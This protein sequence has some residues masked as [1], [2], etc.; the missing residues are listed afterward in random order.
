MGDWQVIIPE[1]G[2]NFVYNPVAM[3]LANYAAGGATPA[4]VTLDTTHSYLGHRSYHVV[5]ALTT[6]SILLT[7]YT[8]ANAIH[9]LTVRVHG[10]LPAGWVCG[11]DVG[12][13]HTM[14]LLATEGDWSVYGHQ[15]SAAESVGQTEVIFVQLDDGV[16]DYYIGHVQ[17]EQ[18]TYPTTPITGD[19]RGF[20]SDGYVWGGTPNDSNSWRKVYERSGG[21]VVDLLDTYNWKV[22]YGVGTGMP[23]IQH[24]TQG[25]ALLPGALYGGHKVLPR[26]LDLVSGTQANTP[27]TVTAARKNF[28]NAIKPDRSV[29]EQPVVFR[30]TGANVN[31]PIEF[32][33]IYDSGLENQITSGV[34]DKPTVRF[35]CYD[36]FAY[37]THTESKELIRYSTIADANYVVWK[38]NGEWANIDAGFDAS[39]LGFVQG[40]DGC[41]YIYGGFTL[42]VPDTDYVAKW[43]PYTEVL[44]ILAGTGA[45]AVV[46]DGICDANGNIYFCGNFTNLGGADGDYIAMWDGAAFQPLSTGLTAAGS[47]LEIG[48]D[49]TLFIGGSFTNFI[50]GSG[51]YITKWDGAA[52]S[53]MGTG[54]QAGVPQDFAIAPNGDLY[55]T[56][57]FTTAGGVANTVQIAKWNGAAWL[58]LGTGLAGG[59]GGY[60]IAS[61]KAGNIY[62]G[63]SFTTADGVSCL[64]IAKWNGKTFEPLGSGLNDICYDLHIDSDGLLYAMGSFTTA[65]G[66]T[67]PDTMAVWNGSTWG[68]LDI[69][70]PGAAICQALETY[71]NDM[72]IGYSDV[73]SA[74]ASYTNSIT[75]SNSGS[76]I[77][78]PIIRIQR[79]GGTSCNLRWIRNETTHQTIRCN[80]SL[81]LGETLTI[82]L[83]PGDRHVTSDYFGDVWRAVLRGSDLATFGLIGGTN[84]ITVFCSEVGAA[85][86]FISW[87]E[88]KITHWSADTAA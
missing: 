83:T 22:L 47:C 74:I 84:Q 10:T 79:V 20:T 9:Y 57:A 27:A 13:W 51:D 60:A 33:C 29:P 55:V 24:H 77:T 75:V 59:S 61:D 46:N 82:D 56:G 64:N 86:D 42:D 45:N 18:N 80:Y 21:K 66:V 35:I 14:T 43:N 78:Y 71:R 2:D 4:V 30:Y 34:V 37:E 5:T 81:L 85:D 17:L 67:L 76:H 16:G 73:G 41:V 70:L 25:M 65:G 7:T 62:V 23:P 12:V 40:K 3:G 39:V 11:I 44:S 28:I 26:V 87:M 48:L 72:Y 58:P 52:F 88:W 15:F 63:G 36:P 69:D 8:L 1:A 50:D 19:L 38:H 6:D 32:H 68:H 31:T 49:G 54:L 53:S